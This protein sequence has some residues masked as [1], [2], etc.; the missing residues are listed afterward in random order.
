MRILYFAYGSNMSADVMDRICAGHRF[1]GVAELAGYRLAFTRRSIRT[2]SGVADIV[3]AAG[4]SV[5][6]ALYEVD[7]SCLAA[8]DEKEG[9]GWAYLRRRLRVRLRGDT[10]ELDAH[11][12]AVI[13]P[14]QAEIRP[15][16][17]YLQGL[18]EAARERGLPED[19][20]ADLATHC[21][22]LAP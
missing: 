6:G 12:Y 20:T 5:W 3:P 21:A 10:D 9:N 13:A 11:A 18:L 17:T 2:A 1:L 22:D 4:F 16:P 19:Y 8:I 14:E 7:G 15:A